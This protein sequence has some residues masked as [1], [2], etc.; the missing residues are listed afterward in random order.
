[1]SNSHKLR[2]L[3]QL[4]LMDGFHGKYNNFSK[5][6]S[7]HNTFQSVEAHGLRN[8]KKCDK[9]LKHTLKA[10]EVMLFDM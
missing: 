2:G 9:L 4:T 10:F 3:L 5:E 6:N 8:L 7:S 1:M